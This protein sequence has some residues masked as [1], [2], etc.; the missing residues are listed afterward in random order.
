MITRIISKMPFI[1]DIIVVQEAGLSSKLESY[2]RVPMT[3]SIG[4]KNTQNTQNS[5]R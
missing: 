2:S 3:L 1:K 4:P 5:V